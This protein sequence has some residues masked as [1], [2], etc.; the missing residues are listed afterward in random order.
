MAVFFRQIASGELSIS[1]AREAADGPGY[2][3]AVAKLRIGAAGDDAALYNRVLENYAT[4][5]FRGAAD[6][7]TGGLSQVL[8]QLQ[9]RDLYLLLTYGRTEED[10]ALFA[11]VFDRLL[12]PKLRSQPPA[13][14]LDDLHD[15]NLRRFLTTAI[16]HHRLEAFLS[17]AGSR[18]QQAESLARSVKGIGAADRPVD[19]TLA[20]AEI[21]ASVQEPARLLQIRDA[22]LAEYARGG[23]SV[24]CT[25][26]WP[27]NSPAT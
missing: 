26:C 19:E 22:I 10:D 17:T 14:L 6:S 1:K 25:G 12:L 27:R 23:P 20:A 11:T 15:L 21:L 4:V 9:A 2:F 24:P 5:L 16:A 3:P 7:G 18:A 13:K 8:R